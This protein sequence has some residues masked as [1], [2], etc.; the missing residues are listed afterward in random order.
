M[1]RLL[2]PLAFV[3]IAAAA[4]ADTA[5][6]RLI[7]ELIPNVPRAGETMFVRTTVANDGPDVARNVWVSVQ[8]DTIVVREIDGLPPPDPSW[9]CPGGRCFV[10]N[11]PPGSTASIPDFVNTLPVSNLT[12]SVSVNATSDTAEAQ[13]AN[14]SFRKAFAVVTFPRVRASLAAPAFADPGLPFAATLA[15]TNDGTAPAQNVVIDVEL[16]A[17]VEVLAL[18]AACTASPGN[19]RCVIPTLE[20]R[21]EVAVKFP[22]TLK[23]PPR[24]E[25][26]ELLFRGDGF[27]A[28]T[29]LYRTFLVTSTSDRGDGSLRRAIDAANAACAPPARCAIQFNI[30]GSQRWQTIA[31]RAALPP[32]R[33]VNLRIDGATQAA[34]SGTANPD[35]PS[36]EISGGYHIGSAGLDIDGRGLQE[37]ANLAING[38]RGDGIAL[39]FDRIESFGPASS[40]HHN[41]IGTDPTGTIA[42]PNRRG[43]VLRETSPRLWPATSIANNVISGNS[44]TGLL[45]LGGGIVVRDNR[46]GVKA[47][48]DEPLPNGGSGLHFDR[49][50]DRVEVAGN[51][52]AFNGESGIAVHPDALYM[53]AQGN[54]IWS[55]GGL[56]IDDGLDGPSPGVSTEDG[57]LANPLVTSAA[58]DPATK[59]TTIRGTAPP[60]T[61]VALYAAT[62]PGEAER[63]LVTA[64]ARHPAGEF[65]AAVTADLRGLYVSGTAT[66]TF[67]G[68][69]PD[70]FTLGRTSELGAG[71]R[72]P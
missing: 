67:L 22:M 69:Y 43:I 62:A 65:G 25:G 56:P 10:G 55:N 13:P 23:A 46:V 1:K 70:T 44:R 53:N 66:R 9:P 41:Y 60:G 24:Y 19:V 14:N 17:G 12:M 18:P 29:T 16:P 11:L 36:I 61:F 45:A 4:H 2:V 15:V 32:I 3:L 47:R 21:A 39:S 8:F 31:L 20:N 40:I 59:A 71:V 49:S 35:G 33:G 54:R 5:D 64:L 50:E 52:I 57:P 27:T 30:V 63:Y 37:L 6:L 42:V 7:V 26:G 68:P 51:V 72:V 58:Y 34:F 48:A 38:F 28:K